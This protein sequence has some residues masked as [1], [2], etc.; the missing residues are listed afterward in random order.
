VFLAGAVLG[1]AGL[2]AFSR[3][4]E[5]WQVV[6]AWT[7]LLGPAMAC[8]F[9]EPAYVGIDQWFGGRQGRPLGV[10][11]VVAGLSA[12]MLALATAGGP[13]MAGLLRDATGSYAVSWLAAAAMFV[14]AIPMILAV[15]R[16]RTIPSVNR[17]GR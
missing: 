6:A 10:L 15:G 11:T 7:L 17:S 5:E 3:A 1:S 12:T 4:T 13:F 2:A 8:T 16:K 14:A 9:Y